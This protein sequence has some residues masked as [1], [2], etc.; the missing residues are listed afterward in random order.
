MDRLHI[1]ERPMIQT[2]HKVGMTEVLLVIDPARGPGVHHE[3]G[4][5]NQQ[6]SVVSMDLSTY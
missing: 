4:S 3:T 5:F 6:H 1:D 2:Q